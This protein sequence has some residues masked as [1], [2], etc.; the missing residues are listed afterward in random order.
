[1]LDLVV[2]VGPRRARLVAE[3]VKP[4]D[5]HP[6]RARGDVALEPQGDPTELPPIL[7]PGLPY[8]GREAQPDGLPRCV[9]IGSEAKTRDGRTHAQDRAI[10]GRVGHPCHGDRPRPPVAE[11]LLR[12]ICRRRERVPVVIDCYAGTP[13]DV[14]RPGGIVEADASC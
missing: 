4:H 13:H 11:G 1:M 14:G 5:V 3:A 8:G 7:R 12:W 10:V 6:G 9:G 2:G